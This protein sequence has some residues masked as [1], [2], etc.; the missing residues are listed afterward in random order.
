MKHLLHAPRTGGLARQYA[1]TKHIRA[2]EVRV[3]GHRVKLS[4]I[5]DPGPVMLFVRHP[6]SRF[7]SV[8]DHLARLYPQVLKTQWPTAEDLA[9]DL[10][11]AYPLLEDRWPTMFRRQSDWVDTLDREYYVGHVSDMQEDLDAFIGEHVPLPD[12]T[13]ANRRVGP[14]S[15]LSQQS[16]DDICEFYLEDLIWTLS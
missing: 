10:D 13:N 8:Y 9:M 6:V 1:L 5:D 14:A 2:G 16:K 7:L 3:Y 15:R 12:D 4:Q 11:R